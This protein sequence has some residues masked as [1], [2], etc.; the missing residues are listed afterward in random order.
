[1][2][3][4]LAMCAAGVDA[5]G[6]NFYPSSARYLD[7]DKA[8]EIC[9]KTKRAFPEVQRIGLFVDAPAEQV[10]QVVG[11]V[12]LDMLQFHGD[13]SPEYCEQF[14]MPYIKVLG[15]SEKTD[16]TAFEA[17]FASAW[18][19]LLDTHDPQMKGGTGRRFDWTLWPSNATSRLVLAGGLNAENVAAAV[20]QTHPFGVDVAGG[21]ETEHK[22][23]K[24]HA[25]AKAFIENAKL[26][27]M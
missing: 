27:E 22:G 25:K 10:R 18:A 5:L 26:L 2:Q 4:S 1:M 9:A 15:V 8:V 20:K 12:D 19:L 11:L 21:V 6:F 16:F 13:E 23:V 17:D 24:D 7:A 14:N 3:D